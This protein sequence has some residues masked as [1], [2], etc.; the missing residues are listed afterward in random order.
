MK[1]IDAFINKLSDQKL[2]DRAHNLYHGAV[3]AVR[4]DN[5]RIY[6]NKMTRL[7]PDVL[8]LG[9]APGYKGCG[10]TGVPFTSEQLIYENAFF[11]DQG[12]G[13]MR[14]WKVREKENTAT[15]VWEE[16]NKYSRL[17]LIWNIFPFHPFK[18]NNPR[19]NRAP[20][21]QELSIGL[22]YLK[23][24]LDLFDIQRI[25]A[26]GRK[27]ESQMDKLDIDS[28][29]IRHP[30]YGGKAQFVQGLSKELE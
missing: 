26:V 12:Y 5:L 13:F 28:V 16:L 15:M 18:K 11:R 2:S 23:A 24:L 21:K 25:L 20:N 8:L 10:C 30:S 17:P 22:E 6:L 3:S 7:K 9:E 14:T 1:E 29:Y 27:P 4:R 19:S